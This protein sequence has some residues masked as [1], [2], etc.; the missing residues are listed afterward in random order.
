M[1]G[2]FVN[3]NEAPFANWIVQGWKTIE[4]RSRNMLKP[5]VGERV[6]IVR[7]K[8]GEKPVVIGVVKITD[9]FRDDVRFFREDTMIPVGSKYDT[10][11]RWMY[12]LEDPAPIS[13]DS[14]Y[15][16]PE[17]AVRHGRSWCEW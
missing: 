13:P 15:P 1:K 11:M 4:T 6:A 3:E 9:S 5:L 17:N 14:W 8:R 2:I 7:T 16:L 10:G 12:V